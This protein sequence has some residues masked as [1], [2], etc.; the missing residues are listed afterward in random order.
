MVLNLFSIFYIVLIKVFFKKTR[1]AVSPTKIYINKIKGVQNIRIVFFRPRR[2]PSFC[3]KKNKNKKPQ[4]LNFP[5]E[6]L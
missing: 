4:E 5:K 6:T 2:E 3:K 1:G